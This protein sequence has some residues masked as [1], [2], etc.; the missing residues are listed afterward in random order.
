VSVES[1]LL[2]LVTGLSR[3]SV[4]FLV[5]SGLSLVFGALRIVNIAH[6]SFYMIGAFV[7]V[8][9]GS[10]VAG[11]AGFLVALVVVPLVVAGIAAFT[12][13]TVLR[14]IYGREHLLQLLGTFA[15]LLIFADAVRFGWG[16]QPQAMRQPD[17]LSGSIQLFGSYFSRYSLF[18]IV[19][20]VVL[21]AAL[22]L[23]LTRTGLGRDIRAGVSDPE[24]LGLVGVNVP[25]LYTSVFALGGGLAGLGGVLSAPQTTVTLG[26]DVSII[27]VAFAVVV[28]GGLG[29]M[30]GTAVGSVVVGLVFSFG[31][32]W[33]PEAALAIVFLV[34]VAVLVWRPQG[35]F[36]VVER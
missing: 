7:A 30:L 4:L 3:A 36:G 21:G 16:E 12:E 17:P 28:I 2:Q 31:I 20:A 32:L 13:V 19:A 1:L 18:L 29:S 25:R 6:G 23:L 14:R 15:F 8:T 10:M 34:M 5:A 11:L 9:M 22:W 24:M 26:M 35:L 33:V 27:L